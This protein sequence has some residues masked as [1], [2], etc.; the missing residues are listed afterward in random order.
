MF[1]WCSGGIGT[2]KIVGNKTGL[3]AVTVVLSILIW[4]KLLGFMG[5]L[6]AVPLT[7]TLKVLF[8]HYLWQRLQAC[9]SRTVA[10]RRKAQAVHA[11][12]QL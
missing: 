4:G 12:V 11:R 7:S 8:S 5:I 1:L 10:L 2:P 6:L 9:P 3:H